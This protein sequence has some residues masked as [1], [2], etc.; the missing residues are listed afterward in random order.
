VPISH[1]PAEPSTLALGI[2]TGGGNDAR[3]RVFT[4][5][6]AGLPRGDFTH[7]DR[8]HRRQIGR[9]GAALQFRNFIDGTRFQHQLE[10]LRDSQ[11][12]DFA[13]YIDDDAFDVESGKQRRR[14]L[15][16]PMGQRAAGGNE[17]AEG[18]RQALRIRFAK[19][20]GQFRIARFEQRPSPVSIK[21]RHQGF[22]L[23][24][25]SVG[26]VRN[27]GNAVFQ[28]IEIKARSPD[29]KEVAL[30]DSGIIDHGGRRRQPLPDRT[31]DFGRNKAVKTVLGTGEVVGRGSGGQDV[32]DIVDL[33]GIGIDDDAARA[34]GPVERKGRL[35]AGGRTR[36]QNR[37][38][39]QNPIVPMSVLC[40][41]ANPADPE[42]TPQMANAVLAETG[43]ALNWLAHPHACEI[44]EPKSTDPVGAA[45]AV[46]SGK[47]VDVVLVPRKGRRKRLL[48]AD[49]DSTMINEEC[50][51]ELADALGLKDTISEITARAMNG[52]IDFEQA[53]D[54]RVGLL[55]GLELKRIE[56]IRRERIT[57][58]PGGRALVQTM[59]AY[60]AHTVLIS[61]GFT[62]FAEHI[63][64]RIGFDEVVANTLL[65]ENGRLIGKVEKPI[66]DKN[67]KLTRLGELVTERGLAPDET[68]AVGDGANDLPMIEAAGFGVALHAKPSVAE[69]APIRIDHG[70]LTALL[71]LQGYAE[72]DIVR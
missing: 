38:S 19:R 1:A 47:P 59:K 15:L 55:K 63:G 42:L 66:V 20:F 58:A 5:Q 10:A 44:T 37:L 39:S 48:I 12:Q 68:L 33:H 34:F 23:S 41:I 16:L 43:G 11:G 70:D 61:G 45:R 60:G 67:R 64:K 65:F 40:L 6:F 7:A 30:P 24:D 72:E 14:N 49:M 56:Q 13:F 57:Y 28:R 52:E 18:A 62:F 27:I 51:D 32:E 69:K 36:Y 22:G 35:A 53:L 29:K 21:G 26:N 54:T 9:Q 2:L 8:L 71:Y 3:G 25:S 4:A 50:I 17:N 46:L 31:A